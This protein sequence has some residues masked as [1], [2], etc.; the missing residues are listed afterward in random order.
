[1]ST[2]PKLKTSAVMQYPAEKKLVCS[3]RVLQLL[4]G[5][6]QRFR[7]YER[8]IRRWI[9]RL[10]LLESQEWSEL[11]SFFLS[12]QGRAGSFT[13]TDPWDGTTYANCSLEEDRVRIDLLGEERAQLSLI[14]RED[15]T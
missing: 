2:F 6:E 11:E 10:N 1:M 3:T 4:D 5:S 13:F 12:M 9:I 8:P 15:L 14:V 7:E